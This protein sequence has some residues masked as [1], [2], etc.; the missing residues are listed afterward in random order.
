MPRYYMGFLGGRVAVLYLVGIA[1][2]NHGTEGVLT[3]MPDRVS[4]DMS[5]LEPVCA[6]CSDEAA[7]RNFS[8]S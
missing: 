8:P 4:A 7:A 3:P 2:S 5:D 1:P 6:A